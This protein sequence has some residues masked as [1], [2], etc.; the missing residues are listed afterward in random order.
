MDGKQTCDTLS[1]I[2]RK[3]SRVEYISLLD[4]KTRSTE[5]TVAAY[6]IE[7]IKSLVQYVIAN[8]FSSSCIGE[9]ILHIEKNCNYEH[10]IDFISLLHKEIQKNNIG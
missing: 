10:L 3:N 8:K 1:V 7:D 5:K 2:S 6:N 9:C 4:S